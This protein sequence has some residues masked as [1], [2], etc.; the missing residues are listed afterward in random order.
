MSSLRILMIL[1]LTGGSA[2]SQPGPD[3]AAIA[4][5][6]D[7]YRAAHGFS[8]TILVAR[9]GQPIFRRS[10]GLAYRQTPDS[11]THTTPYSI[12]SVTKLFTSIR[13]LQLAEVGKVD[14]QAAAT[15]YLPR[16]A[17]QVPAAVTVHHLLLHLSGLPNEKNRLYRRHLS[18]EEMVQKALTGRPAGPVG[19]FHYNNVDYLLLGLIIEAVTGKSWQENIR[20]HILEPLGMTQSGFLAYGQYPRHFAFT[21]RKKGKQLKQDPLIHIENFGSAGCMYATAGDLLK[22]DQAL[23]GE[24]LLS[25]ESRQCLAQS[26]PEY[27]Y[28]GY[29]VWNYRYPFVEAQPTIMERRGGIL[30]AN[31]VLVRMMDDKHTL[32]ILSHDDRFNPDS[33]GDEGNL[34][35]MLIRAL[36]E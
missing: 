32:I 21:Y 12:A 13:I 29:G 17:P 26:Y 1:L 25:A 36:Y 16:F 14:L 3:S 19:T 34:R 9:H 22:L 28:A 30:G 24:A 20:Q 35:E 8:G 2:W 23:Y 7:T 6:V 27:N 18:A 5:V 10:Y 4:A 11:L 15:Q 33:F 31:V